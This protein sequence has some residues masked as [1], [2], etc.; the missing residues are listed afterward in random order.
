[1][2]TAKGVITV[3]MRK[4][5]GRIAALRRGKG[6]TQ[7]QLGDRLGVT[8]QAVSKWERGVSHS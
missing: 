1:M 6:L 3:D 4:V 7:E 2:M 8:F 5:G